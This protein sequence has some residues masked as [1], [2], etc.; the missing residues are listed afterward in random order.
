MFRWIGGRYSSP[1][2]DASQDIQ[3]WTATSDSGVVTLK[4]TRSRMTSDTDNDWSFTD[5]ADDCYYFIFPVGGGGYNAG[6]KS[7][8]KHDSTPQFSTDKIC[9][10]GDSFFMYSVLSKGVSSIICWVR[11]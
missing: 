7:V 6:S 11:G 8:S 5:S 10:T 4:F 1:T 3:D 9:I 2:K